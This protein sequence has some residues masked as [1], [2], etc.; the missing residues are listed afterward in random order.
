MCS[1]TY[2]LHHQAQGPLAPLRIDS[3]YAPCTSLPVSLSKRSP[4]AVVLW[5]DHDVRTRFNK[6]AAIKPL[7]KYIT[8]VTRTLSHAVLPFA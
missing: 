8:R 3:H 7:G 1:S 4:V 5:I 6:V 2:V